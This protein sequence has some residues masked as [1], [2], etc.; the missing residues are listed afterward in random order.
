V[1][2]NGTRIRLQ[3]QPLQILLLLL[4]NA[5]DLVTREQ[6]QKKLWASVTFVYFDNA[7]NSAMRKL[8]FSSV[9]YCA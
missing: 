2:K 4:E 1:R 3:D 6:I 5:G 7:I 9:I 8:R